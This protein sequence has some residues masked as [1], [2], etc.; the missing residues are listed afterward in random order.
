[1]VKK[2]MAAAVIVITFFAAETPARP[3]TFRKPIKTIAVQNETAAAAVKRVEETERHEDDGRRDQCGAEDAGSE[4]E[5]SG[6]SGADEFGVPEPGEGTDDGGD[7]PGVGTEAAEAD[8]EAAE[9]PERPDGEDDEY[10]EGDHQGTEGYEEENALIYVGN[11]TVTFY[12]QCEQC[13]GR[14]AWSNSTASGAV[15]QA[16]WTVAAGESFPFGTI[17]YIEGF[18]TYEVQDRGVPDGWVDI[19]VN[20]HSEIPGYGMTEAAVYIVN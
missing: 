6:I 2:I 3:Y 19:Y 13:C 10:P 14:W 15:P 8:I 7:F 5:L 18:G 9:E 12:C 4:E 1:M 11:W 20:D 16:G 17:L